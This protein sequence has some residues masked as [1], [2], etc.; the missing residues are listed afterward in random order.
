[1]IRQHDVTDVPSL[2]ETLRSCCPNLGTDDYWFRGH[3]NADDWKL[4]PS[5]HRRYSGYAEAVL[6]ARFKLAASTRHPKCPSDRDVAGW[7]CLM[8]HWGL[9]TRLLDWSASPLVAAYFAV[10]HEPLA[11]PAAIWVL[12]PR[13]LNQRSTLRKNGIP[14]L[15][16]IDAEPMLRGAFEG[17]SQPTAWAVAAQEI[18]LRMSL[19]QGFFTIHGDRTALEDRPD[20]ENF[21]MKLVVPEDARKVLATELWVMGLRRSTLFPD[22]ANLAIELAK[23]ER[24][25]RLA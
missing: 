20:A 5:V 13:E 19:Q 4:I 25:L 7:L 12:Y 18:D 11:G 3:S 22:L 23:E 8:Q 21:L 10:S 2:I 1:M 24:L 14:I 6:H 15:H 9:P 17:L 16:S